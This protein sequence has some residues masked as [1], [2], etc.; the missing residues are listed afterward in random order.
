M[1]FC[2][3]SALNVLMAWATAQRHFALW[4]VEMSVIPG[5]D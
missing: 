3:Y 2:E 1:C 4:Q 5:G